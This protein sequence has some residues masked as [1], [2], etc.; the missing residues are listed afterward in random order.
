L[1]LPLRI[2]AADE[3]SCTIARVAARKIGSAVFGEANP[4][5][6]QVDIRR[7][8]DSPKSR[9]PPI[10]VG[11]NAVQKKICSSLNE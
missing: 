1:N 2:T 5:R 10:F 7:V 4:A 9:S 6:S 3:R 11:E 8:N